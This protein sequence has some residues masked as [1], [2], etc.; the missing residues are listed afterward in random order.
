M[1]YTKSIMKASVNWIG[2]LNTINVLSASVSSV[3][4]D[5][6]SLTISVTID[7]LPIQLQISLCTGEDTSSCF[8][9]LNDSKT[10]CGNEKKTFDIEFTIPCS[11]HDNVPHLSQPSLA[12]MKITP[13]IHLRPWGT[14]KLITITNRITS[15]VKLA[16]STLITDEMILHLNE[17][18][19]PMLGPGS[20]TCS[21]LSDASTP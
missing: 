11:E 19:F 21:A 14:F 3:N 8:D 1:V 9:L 15:A 6:I 7:E 17:I 13:D 10:C 18:V 16:M 4:E 5:T 12:S 20:F 2:G